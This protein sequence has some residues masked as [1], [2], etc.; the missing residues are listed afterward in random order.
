MPRGDVLSNTNTNSY[1]VIVVASDDAPGTDAAEGSDLIMAS[2][3]KVTINVIN[4]SERRSITLAPKYPHVDDSDGRHP[5]RWR[6]D[7]RDH[8][9]GVDGRWSNRRR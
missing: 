7:A 8:H 6:R 2:T 4:V 9:L 1:K 3:K 5:D